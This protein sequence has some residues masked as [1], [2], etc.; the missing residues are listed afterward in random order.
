MQPDDNKPVH[1]GWIAL[2][3]VVDVE[4]NPISA[5]V[6]LHGEKG[7]TPRAAMVFAQVAEA[8]QLELHRLVLE[9]EA[10]DEAPSRAP[11]HAATCANDG[12]AEA[13]GCRA[14][15]TATDSGDA[16]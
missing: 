2:D 12:P 10:V 15:T 16:E 14:G 4:G 3:V 8:A 9:Q 5:H 1:L 6:M 13:C 11:Q 7:S